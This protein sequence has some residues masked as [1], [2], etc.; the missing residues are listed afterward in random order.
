VAVADL[1]VVALERLPGLALAKRQNVR[2]VASPLLAATSYP[3]TSG[4]LGAARPA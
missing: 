3:S 2:H 4:K 1:G